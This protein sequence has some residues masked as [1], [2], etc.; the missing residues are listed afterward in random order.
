MA[1]D[2]DDDRPRKKSRSRDDDDEDDD[3]RPRKKSRSRD[4][5]DEDDDE[6]R[7]RKKRRSRDD[8]EDDDDDRRDRKKTKSGMPGMLLASAIVS[9]S[10]G[11]IGMLI[12]LIRLV[13]GILGLIESM[14]FGFALLTATMKFLFFFSFFCGLL[15]LLASI[16]LLV[17]G[18]LLI[19]RSGGGK[20]PALGAPI[21]L[22][23]LPLLEIV[24]IVAITE[25]LFIRTGALVVLMM[26]ML[27]AI[28]AAICNFIML[29]NSNVNRA[30]R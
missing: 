5:D 6:D 25:G 16:A 12:Y 3:E 30:L 29:L 14:R 21:A 13:G 20:V 28:G 9:M 2:N 27:M 7:R 23:V 19:R 26:T 22:F 1:R 15:S 24:T 11:G 8:D 18:I 4:E 17:G 10:C